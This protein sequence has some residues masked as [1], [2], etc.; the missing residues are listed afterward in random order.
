M[1]EKVTLALITSAR[2][3]RPYFQSHQVVVKK[4][5][6]IKQVL[7]KCELSGRMVACSVEL[8][9]F[10]LQYKSRDPMKTQFVTDFMVEFARNDQITPDW[11]SL[12][13]DDVQRERKQ[14]MNHP[15]RLYHSR[16]SPQAQLQSLKQSCRVRDNH[17]KSKTSKRSRD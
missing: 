5:Y 17:C 16:A 8:L 12:Y 11:W 2:R 4:N 15:Q 13:I 7:Q 14:G 1:I 6:P 3:L 9:V 10:N